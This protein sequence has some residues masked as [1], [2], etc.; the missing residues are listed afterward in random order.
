MFKTAQKHFKT[1]WSSPL[2]KGESY[3]ILFLLLF[4]AFSMVCVAQ[5]SSDISKMEKDLS[6][7]E[8]ELL[9]IQNS[10]LDISNKVTEMEKRLDELD[11]ILEEQTLN[12]EIEINEPTEKEKIVAMVFEIAP[13][14][15]IPPYMIMAM[16]ERESNYDPNATNGQY[17][18]LLQ[19]TERWHKSRMDEL[20]VSD[21]YDPA[22]NITVA[23]SY[24]KDLYEL[25]EDQELVLMCY[26][27]DNNKAMDLW[28]KGQVSVYAAAV[29][30][31]MRELEEGHGEN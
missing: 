9:N 12:A 19:I 22:G 11:H 23:C 24:L 3:A 20:G 1:F 29:I 18:G 14:Y 17:K 10:V 27:M 4:S 7:I 25:Y 5:V 30:E 26:S 31:R 28:R 2:G 8:T 15:D 21:L 6:Q 13:T 16:I